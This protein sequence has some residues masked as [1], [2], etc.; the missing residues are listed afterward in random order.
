MIGPVKVYQIYYGNWSP[1]KTCLP[2]LS[3]ISPSSAYFNIEKEYYHIRQKQYVRGYISYS[4]NY[5]QG[6]N[7]TQNAIHNV[8]S[9]A[10]QRNTLP[11]NP[12]V[13]YVVYTSPDVTLTAFVLACV[14]ITPITKPISTPSSATRQRNALSTCSGNQY[15]RSP[16]GQ[17][18][19][20]AMISVLGHE[21]MEAI[22]DPLINA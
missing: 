5:S 15:P 14:A 11:S 6:K 17:F 10:I 2:I 4:D 20:D 9:S 12:N 8:V 1:P 21:P 19:A 7:L 3:T 16:N 13:I 22:S 18:G